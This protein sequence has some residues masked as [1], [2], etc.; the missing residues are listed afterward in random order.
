M[1]V[2]GKKILA[3]ALC[4]ALAFCALALAACGDNTEAGTKSVTIIIGDDVFS[5]ETE[6]LYVHDLLE[7]M[8][9]RGDIEYEFEMDTYGATVE[10]LN[11]L[12]S[13]SDWTMWIGVYIDV[14][15]VELIS[16]GYETTHQGKT[17]Y[18]SGLGVSSL[19]VMD[20]VTYLFVQN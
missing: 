18:S 16:P 15:D 12:L 8:C 1:F 10:K 11:N 2:K 7:E 9:E 19:P 20:G 3:I 5:E 17:Y 14:D 4:L 13:T 6:A